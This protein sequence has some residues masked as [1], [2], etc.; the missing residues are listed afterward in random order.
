MKTWA[1]C[2]VQRRR[3]TAGLPLAPLLPGYGAAGLAVA[4][5]HRAGDG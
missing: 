1:T 4:E 2:N 5:E 3:A